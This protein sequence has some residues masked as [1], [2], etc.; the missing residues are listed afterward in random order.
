MPNG[1][2]EVHTERHRLGDY[3]TA[4]RILPDSQANPASFRLVFHRRP[5]AGRFWKDL[6][7]NIL[8]EIEAAPQKASIEVESKGEME[9]SLEQIMAA[10]VD[11][12]EEPMTFM[13]NKYRGT[14]EY[15]QARKVMIAAA[16]NGTTLFYRPTISDILGLEGSG[17]HIPAELGR[18]CGE[19][20]EDEHLAGRPLLSA[21]II[22]QDNRPGSGFY[23]LARGLG[24][25]RGRSQEAEDEYW[26]AELRRVHTFWGQG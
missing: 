26:V 12:L 14:P 6:M 9:S 22:N 18:L 4:I 10:G 25:L 8:R 20:S 15:A 17:D 16:R 2:E 5:D 23:D 24:L 11:D 3:F 1:V 21:V 19:I 7:V 13:P